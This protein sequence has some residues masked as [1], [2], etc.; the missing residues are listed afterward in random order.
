M[1]DRVSTYC[2]PTVNIFLY[3]NTE[4]TDVANAELF[5]AVQDYILKNKTF[6]LKNKGTHLKVLIIVAHTINQN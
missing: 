2:Q 3:G 5:S 4:L 6:L 1:L